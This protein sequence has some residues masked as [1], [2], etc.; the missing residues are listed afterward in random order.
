MSPEQYAN[1]AQMRFARQLDQY[2]PVASY[3]PPN[4]RQSE[5]YCQSLA[6]SHYENFSV[7]SRLIPK[8]L[9]Q[10]FFNVY[11]FCRWADDLSDEV[12]DANRSLE[13]LTWWRAQLAACFSGQPPHHP[14]F[15]AL[16]NSIQ[17]HRFEITPF[18]NL[19]AAFEQDQRRNRYDTHQSVQHYC[20]GS[21]NPVGRIVLKMANADTSEN[22]QLS[23]SICTGL[24]LANFCQDVARDAAIDRIYMPSQHFLAHNVSESMILSGQATP[25]LKSALAAWCDLATASLRAGL[26]LID[27]VPT[28]LAR[29][30]FLFAHGGLTLLDRIAANRFDVWKT[31]VQVTKRQKLTLLARSLLVRPSKPSSDRPAP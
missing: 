16:A 12:S 27:R 19:I 5:D 28:W 1:D 15:I 9:R 21:A 22:C 23:D 8:S 17:K 13:L 4:I 20:Q 31:R 6:T 11:A 2:G 14:V 3:S 10:D 29:D 18:E 26:P 30:I 25:E 24:Q 7:A